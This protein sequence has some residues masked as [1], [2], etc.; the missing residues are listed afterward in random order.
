M[1]DSTPPPSPPNDLLIA[2]CTYQ[3]SQNIQAMLTGLRRAFPV[4]C[5]L[6]VDD[7]SPD[8][9][10]DLVREAQQT[11]RRIELI[12]R[13]D[14]RGLGSAIVDAMKYAVAQG[15]R[16]FVNLDADQSHDPAQLPDLVRVARDQP[17]V[18]VV[19]GS[20]YV[21]GGKIVGWP[22]RRRLMSKL[23]NRFA[24]GF[25]KLPV[26]DCSG[27][28]RCYRTSALDALNLN[29]LQCTGYAVL[30]EL[31]VKLHRDGRRMVEVPITFTERELGHSK[32]TFKEALRSVRFMLRLA[33]TLR[34]N[35]NVP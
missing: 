11:D 27:S 33:I 28:M 30:E 19:I 35:P 3:E 23:V 1:D 34:R 14:K 31:L 22:I 29:S 9:T 6:V 4:A 24:T 7:N 16:F 15:Y 2:V 21:P 32:L 20:R 26:K 5:L 10:A 8:G 13:R 18:A 12:V 25:L 17:E